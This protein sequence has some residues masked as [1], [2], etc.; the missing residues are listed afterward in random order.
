M[1]VIEVFR[2]AYHPVGTM[3]FFD[4]DGHRLYT[5]ERPWLNNKPYESCI[6]E[7]IYTANSYASEKYP[8]SFEL[9]EVPNRSVILFCHVANYPKDVQGCFG[10]G[11]QPMEDKIAVAQSRNACTLFEKILKDETQLVLNV[12]PWKQE[13]GN[14]DH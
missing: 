11:M 5:I 9:Q 2:Y 13:Y 1:R 10:V 3:G 7:G 4:L 12:Q 8:F 6:I 14:A